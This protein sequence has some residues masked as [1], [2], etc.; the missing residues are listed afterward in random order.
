VSGAVNARPSAATRIGLMIEIVLIFVVVGPPIGG[1]I[2]LMLTAAGVGHPRDQVELFNG[3]AFVL[4]A[5]I[6][7]YPFGAAPAAL[8]GLAIGIKQ[9]FFG[10][11][12]WPMA[13]AIGLI[14]GTVLLK[15]LDSVYPRARALNVLPLPEYS[16][17][18]ILTCLVPT[19]L[20]WSLVRS[21]YF[22]P[23]SCMDA[24]P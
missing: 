17:I 1:V 23:P 21:Q 20:C 6:F 19:M 8:A 12:T 14:D 3:P 11:T 7:S 24:G 22:A 10:P 18:L 9:A 15:G 2:I 5:A 13:L 4:F 16:A